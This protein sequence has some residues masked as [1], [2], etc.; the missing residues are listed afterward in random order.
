MNSKDKIISYFNSKNE[1]IRLKQL[2]KLIDKDEVLK[3][4]IKDLKI[5]QQK[6]INSKEYNLINQYKIDKES[7]DNLLSEINDYPFMSEYLDLLDYANNEL[8][9]LSNGISEEIDKLING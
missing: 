7:Y 5:I 8:K 3:E 9:Y 1:I 2:E 4:K 6:M